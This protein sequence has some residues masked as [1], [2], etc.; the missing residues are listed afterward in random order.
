MKLRKHRDM[1]KDFVTNLV[2]ENMR[3]MNEWHEQDEQIDHLKCQNQQ[4]F[5]ALGKK[6]WEQMSCSAMFRKANTRKWRAK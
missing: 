1:Q 5:A 3:L 6:V 2:E 4:L